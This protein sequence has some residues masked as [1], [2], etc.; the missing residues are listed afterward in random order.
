MTSP[1][2]YRNALSDNTRWDGFRFRQGDIV[3]TTPPK[4]G[5][6]WTQMI[7]AL[8]VFQTP[9]LRQNLEFISP[10]LEMLTRPVD[11]VLDDLERQTHRRVIKSHTPL[12]G[13]P[14]DDRVTYICVG[15]DPRDV[16]LSMLRHHANN[17]QAVV[18]AARN[19]VVGT[20]APAPPPRPDAGNS[21]LLDRF[22]SW[23]DDP[24]PVAGALSTL[25]KTM[26]QLCLFWPPDERDNLVL[27]HYADLSDD[28]EGQ[29]RKLAARLGIVIDEDRW[30]GL[31]EAAGFEAMRDNADRLAPC[32][33]MGFW[34]D[35]R[36][37]FSRGVSTQWSGLLDESDLERY[38]R[39]V[40]ELCPADLSAWV[41]RGAQP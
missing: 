17:N 20:D 5:T 19:A 8:L 16:A 26:H 29:M 25:A 33:S 24:T 11:S 7:C 14:Y 13:L 18:M 38:D 22:W 41:H 31:V 10:W 40:A 34:R 4:C 21:S 30:P 39:R 32:A 1:V 23:V 35:N 37:F 27:L 28:L 2:V 3:V 15:R 6:T 9:S 36:E 12:D